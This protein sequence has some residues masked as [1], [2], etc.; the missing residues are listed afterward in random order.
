MLQE[1]SLMR[2]TLLITYTL[3]IGRVWYIKGLQEANFDREHA[4]LKLQQCLEV[5]R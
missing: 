3:F 4:N 1:L 5:I 2:L